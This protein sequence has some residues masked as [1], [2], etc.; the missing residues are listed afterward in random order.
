M[1]SSAFFGVIYYVLYID[2]EATL[3]Y[4][5]RRKLIEKVVQGIENEMVELVPQNIVKK[6]EDLER[7][8]VVAWLRGCYDKAAN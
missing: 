1:S 2:G 4:I 6:T 8:L 5:Q 3:P 7:F